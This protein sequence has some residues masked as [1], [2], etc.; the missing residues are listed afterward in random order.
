MAVSIIRLSIVSVLLSSS[1]ALASNYKID[2][3][4]SQIGFSVKH[5]VVESVPGSFNKFEG[6]GVYDEKTKKI[7]NIKIT[8][9]TD[10]IFTNEPDRD[11]HLKSADFFDT[12]KFPDLK[13]ESTGSTDAKTGA[14]IKGKITIKGVTKD[15]TLKITDWGGT[16][17]DPWGNEKVGFQ[18]TGKIDRTLFG[19]T[20]NKPL[21]KA[22]GLTVSNDVALNLSISGMKVK[23]EGKK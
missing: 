16:V 22:G 17:T 14:E 2:A 9:T 21:A 1:F 10:S 23:E 20:W 6:T 4:H 3:G 11:K 5:L 7:S 15:L 8:I 13:F 12:A 18:A 19:L